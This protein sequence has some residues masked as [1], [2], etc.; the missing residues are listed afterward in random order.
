MPCGEIR[1][2]VTADAHTKAIGEPRAD[3]DVVVAEIAE[4]SLHDMAR[5]EFQ[6][7]QIVG[8]NAAHERAGGGGVG[9]RHDL[10]LDD[11]EGGRHTRQFKDLVGGGGV[12]G[13]AAC[14]GPAGLGINAEIAV[15]AQDAAQ[16]IGA[17]PVHHRHHDDQSGDAE[18]NPEQREDRDDRD[19]PFLPPRPQIAECDHAFERAENHAI[20]RANAASVEM[21]WRS[22]ERRFL[23]ST[24]PALR[25]RGPITIWSGIPIK[26]IA[27]NLAPGDSSRSS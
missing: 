4:R 7:A 22:P 18:R 12:I 27:A 23:C 21:S 8:A 16:Q 11:R 24:A 26:S 13:K 17:K 5:D 2:I 1:V 20:S 15:E 6:R 10:A 3:G 14:L 9:G 25:P 19:E